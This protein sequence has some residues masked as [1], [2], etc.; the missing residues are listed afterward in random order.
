M[1]PKGAFRNFVIMASVLTI[2][3]LG[4]RSELEVI[5]ITPDYPTLGVSRPTRRGIPSLVVSTQ[6]WIDLNLASG[7][8][9]AVVRPTGYRLYDAQGVEIMY[10]R[11]YIGT[12][13]S[14]PTTLDL[15]PGRYL[16]RPD[17]PGRRAPIFWVVVEAGKATEV[18]VRK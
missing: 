7:D 13:D 16:V 9:G 18:D 15:N 14:E 10:V 8:D 2:G 1:N 12:L 6:T 17:K 5:P 4:C 11:N 3:T